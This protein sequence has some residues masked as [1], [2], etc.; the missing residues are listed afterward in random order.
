MNKTR[1]PAQRVRPV[2]LATALVLASLSGAT[3][4]QQTP[5]GIGDAL[6]QTSPTANVP[7][8]ANGRPDVPAIGGVPMAPPMR[9]LPQGAAVVPVQAF[10]IVGNRVIPTEQL[11]ALVRSAQGQSLSLVELDEVATRITRHYRSAGYFVARAYIP[12]QEVSGGT[13]TIRVVEGNYGRFILDNRAI[14]RDDIVQGLLDDIKSRDIV[15]LDTLE[16]V[17]LIINDTPGARVVRADV[18]PGEKVGTSDFAIGT[19]ATPGHDGYAL[20][21][22]HGSRYTGKTRL[23]FNGNWNSPT[24]RGDRLS[25]GGLATD[26]S[27]LLNGRLA[28]SSLVSTN[29]TRAEAV[30]SQTQYELR[31]LYA[32][33]GAT[34]TAQSL[35]LNLTTPYKRTR[36]HSIELGMGLAR[37]ELK[38]D[39]D[40]TGT[41]TRKSSTAVS[42]RVSTVLERP[43]FGFDGVTQASAAVTVGDLSFHDAAARSLDAAGA[44]TEGTYAKL[45]LSA[46]RVL[47]LPRAFTLTG[48]FS[49]QAV[50]NDK[51]LDGSERMS[52]SGASAVAAYP[53]G[54]LAGDHAALLRVELSHPV[55]QWSSAQFS[56]NVF[57]TQGWARAAK[58]LPG[59]GDRSLGDVGLGLNLYAAN[60]LLARLQ[61]AHRITGGEPVS[62]PASR[63]RVLLQVGWMF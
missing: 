2:A 19:E 52:V 16:R 7:P 40:A 18:M 35:E 36:A 51:N 4:A 12:A 61:L 29:G 20:L 10:A 28:Y 5:P 44:R 41:T 60:G 63:T 31:D 37:R 14:V 45:N 47:A 22:N 54:E 55:G 9:A 62:E 24:E 6:R 1:L 17:M 30:L 57:T 23:S 33:L 34:G 56:A 50:L 25:L 15:S 43:W 53:I 49:G 8:P 38:D 27:G 13:I 21:D 48:S 11:M 58:P 42:A 3:Q 26:G 46:S 39:V 59:Q 32:P